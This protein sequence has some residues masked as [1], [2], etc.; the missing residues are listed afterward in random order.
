M[1]QILG[2]DGVT[3]QLSIS[4]L[5][6]IERVHFL[7]EFV[8]LVVYLLQLFICSL[9]VVGLLID[10]REFFLDS[11]E[12]LAHMEHS[13]VVSD[14]CE[15]FFI[16]LILLLDDVIAYRFKS[17]VLDVEQVIGGVLETLLNGLIK[18]FNHVREQ[19]NDLADNRGEWSI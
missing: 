18:E 5:F 6:R 17:I 3:A 14:E 8:T 4:A 15:P 1:I 11:S 19:F 7:I 13:Q 10:S 9:G 2:Q 16:L 12:V